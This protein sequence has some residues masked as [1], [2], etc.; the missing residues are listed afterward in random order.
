[1]TLHVKKDG[2]TKLSIPYTLG[3]FGLPNFQGKYLISKAACE[4]D[5]VNPSILVTARPTDGT[6]KYYLA[7]GL[8][9]DGNFLVDDD[10]EIAAKQAKYDAEILALHAGSP[11]AGNNKHLGCCEVCS[12]AIP[13]GYG[14]LRRCAADTGC[15]QHHDR[16]GW[17]LRCADAAA[18]AARLPAA[19][20]AA[21]IASLK[22]QSADARRIAGGALTY[23]AD[24]WISPEEQQARHDAGMAKAAAL[25]ARAAALENSKS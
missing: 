24:G 6:K 17:H 2:K 10:E 18:C 1:M 16:D 23:D 3:V 9:P 12:A 14:L 15:P 22:A 20:C 11:R 7:M 8:N 13:V 25:A 21:E 19:R 4:A 5:G